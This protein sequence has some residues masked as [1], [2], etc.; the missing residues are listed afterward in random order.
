[1]SDETGRF[2][3]L[4]HDKL[5]PMLETRG[6]TFLPEALGSAYVEAIIDAARDPLLAAEAVEL[7]GDGRTVAELARLSRSELE[8]LC[9]DAAGD[10]P[11]YGLARQ[12][13]AE[14]IGHIGSPIGGGMNS[15]T[16]STLCAFV[17]NGKRYTYAY[18]SDGMGNQYCCDN[19]CPIDTDDGRSAF[20]DQV[21]EWFEMLW[22]HSEC[23]FEEGI[24]PAERMDE[25]R[26]DPW[27][28][29]V[30]EDY[31]SRWETSDSELERLAAELAAD[32]EIDQ[33]LAR[34]FLTEMRASGTVETDHPLGDR[35]GWWLIETHI[36]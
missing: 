18:D 32:L 36:Q 29:G 26:G 7:I 11:E 16:S 34:T 2:E 4:V 14:E 8:E 17:C 25:L 12:L 21:I 9:S 19:G 35:A 24:I 28:H 6:T 20:V 15:G 33:T 1:M 23:W 22:G 13:D 27:E 31:F 3:Q 5:A 10:N 30:I